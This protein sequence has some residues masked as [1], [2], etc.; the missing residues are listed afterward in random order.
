MIRIRIA[1]VCVV[2][3]TCLFCLKTSTIFE[4]FSCFNLLKGLEFMTSKTG[5]KLLTSLRTIKLK[6]IRL[7]RNRMETIKATANVVWRSFMFVVYRCLLSVW[8]DL[9]QLLCSLFDIFSLTELHIFV[10]VSVGQI[11]FWIKKFP[12]FLVILIFWTM[13]QLSKSNWKFKWEVSWILLDNELQ[14]I[15]YTKK[16]K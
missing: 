5:C 15:L 10:I 6:V 13:N 2:T 1:R 7:V 14:L 16:Y 12:I 4:A 8:S 3:K 11:Y 9:T